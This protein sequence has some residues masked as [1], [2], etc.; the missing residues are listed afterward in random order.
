MN[1][2][3]QPVRIGKM[4][5]DRDRHFRERVDTSFFMKTSRCASFVQVGM[6]SLGF[7]GGVVLHSEEYDSEHM[8]TDFQNWIHAPTD[9]PVAS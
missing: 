3:L 4:A 8:P 2:K 1:L 6:N 7:P 5:G 9:A